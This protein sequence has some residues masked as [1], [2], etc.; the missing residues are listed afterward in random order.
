MGMKNKDVTNN[1]LNKERVAIFNA[2]K[3]GTEEEQQSAVSDLF[4]SIEKNVMESATKQIDTNNHQMNDAQIL[5]DRGVRK[6]LTNDERKYFNAVIDNG[7]FENLNEVFP[8]TIIEDTMSNLHRNHVLLQYVDIKDTAALAKYIF[9][10]PTK[11]T[12]F[13]G[14]ICDDIREMIK[15]GFQ[16]IDAV[17]HKLSGY[18]PVCKGMLELGPEWLAAYVIECMDEAMSFSLEMAVISGDGK[19]K[20]VGMTRAL[21]GVVDGVHPAKVKIE[22][23]DLEPKSLG[24][25]MAKFARNETLNGE[26]L[27][28]IHPATYW[29]VVFPTFAIRDSNGNWVLDR[30]PIG[31]KIIPSYAADEGDAI[32]G[33]GKN[34]FLGVSGKAR[35]NRYD[36]TLAIEDMDLFIAKF[37]GYGQP[38]DENAF[39]VLDISKV[40]AEETPTEPETKQL[41]T[42]E[43]DEAK[44]TEK[45]STKK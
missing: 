28:I 39:E 30:L 6:A 40:G 11:A 36:Q 1:V 14:D 41:K 21:T 16:I 25:V 45:K 10:K 44:D 22:M 8:E 32:M 35:I 24:K 27:F 3:N 23:K 20:P 18:I 19:Q 9:A 34:Y 5:V 2:L 42:E 13:W 37:Y 12:A 26:M 17:S 33:V 29:E 43:A 38:K 15:N 4:S 31:A 7:G